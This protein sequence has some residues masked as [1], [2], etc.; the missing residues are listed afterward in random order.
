MMTEKTDVV[1]KT[2]RWDVVR[3][4]LYG[5]L[6]MIVQS[7]AIL[8]AIRIFSAPYS[9][10]PYVPAAF[11]MGY[12]FTPMILW[13][14]RKRGVSTNACLATCYGFGG[15][16]LASASFTQS[17]SLYLALISCSLVVFAQVLPLMTGLYSSN[18]PYDQRGRR[19][20]TT[21]FLTGIASSA[22]AWIAGLVMDHNEGNWR[23]VFLAGALCAFLSAIVVMRIPPHVNSDAGPFR[24]FGH[25]SLMFKDKV[26]GWMLLGWMFI[27]FG[28]LMML[29]LRV[30]YV[31]NPAHGVLAT[32]EQVAL[33]TV[34]I[35]CLFNLLSVKFWG[36][37]FD[38][39]NLITMRLVINAILITYIGLFFFSKSMPLLYL[40]AALQGM[41]VGAYAVIW[42]LWVTRLAPSTAKTEDYMGL[43]TLTTGLR[44]ITSPFLGFFLIGSINTLSA[45]MVGAGLIVISCFIFWPLRNEKR[46]SRR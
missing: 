42:P 21:V 31:A 15:T 5:V 16:L 2:Y 45:A 46:L 29:P 11:F 25:V 33:I 1:A 7:L 4:G 38:R 28:N 43:H 17:M 14:A 30:E 26:F 27:G 24:P 19:L 36:W 22:S 3:G 41:S 39:W 32:N 18:Y 40:A 34:T 13:L 23:W 35:P 10:K 12:M 8:V 9:L 6:D 44:G 20:S 37:I